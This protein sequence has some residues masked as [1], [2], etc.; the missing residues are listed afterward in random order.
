[1]LER[2]PC[3]TPDVHELL[4]A[5]DRKRVNAAVDALQRMLVLTGAGSEEQ[6]HGWPAVLL[7]V[8]PRRYGD[9][10]RRLPPP[11]EARREVADRVLAAV[12][13]LSAADLAGA[14]GRRKAEVVRALDE[15]ADGGVATAR[16]EDGV[17]IWVP[18][19]R[20]TRPRR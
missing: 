12:G 7:D 8:L 1:M 18:R 20:P 16:D 17:R 10:L 14:L 4:A 11:E 6:E 5:H 19:R 3:S 15:L 9:R 2:G 13:E